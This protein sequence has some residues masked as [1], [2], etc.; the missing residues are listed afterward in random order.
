MSKLQQKY[1]DLRLAVFG[2]V[3]LAGILVIVWIA[4]NPEHVGHMVA[5][6]FDRFLCSFLLSITCPEA[7]NP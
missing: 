1:S 4:F 3:D 5:V 7:Y 2:L 6:W